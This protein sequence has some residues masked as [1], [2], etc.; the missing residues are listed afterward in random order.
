MCKLLVHLG[1]ILGLGKC[2]LRPTTC[3]TYLG[4][5]VNSSLQAFQIP[6]GKK[7][8]FAALR[9]EVLSG[10]VN[11]PIKTLQRLMGKAISFSLAF[12]GTKFFIR[13]MATAVGLASGTGLAKIT[14]ALKEEIL[15][16]RFLDD[17]TGNVPWRL[18][19]HVA[20]EI[21]TDASQS[22][23]AGVMYRQPI[24]L[25]LGD[26]WEAPLTKENIN[27]KEFWAVAKV[28]EALPAEIRDCRVR[29]QVDN[30]AVLHTWMGRGGRARGIYPVAKRIFHST[31]LSLQRT[32]QRMSFQDICQLR[33]LCCHPSVGIRS[34]TCLVVLLVITST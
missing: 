33:T 2:V 32:I 16:W 26:F 30:Q 1:Y 8:S 31:P 14:P 24:D 6:V 28:L 13:E 3:I 12:P 27:I 9:E 21:S 23:W 20:I 18:E 5:E 19:K 15:F 10:S 4:M 7:V 34:K 11:I 17:W 29:V 25:V 22:R